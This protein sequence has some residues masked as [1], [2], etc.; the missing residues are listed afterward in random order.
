[1]LVGRSKYR[2]LLRQPISCI[3]FAAGWYQGKVSEG[4]LAICSYRKAFS[5]LGRRIC[6][7]VLDIPVTPHHK[8]NINVLSSWIN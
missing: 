5:G 4:V 1:M 2:F 7:F 3:Q 8:S 6:V